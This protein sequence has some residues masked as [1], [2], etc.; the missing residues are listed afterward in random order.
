MKKIFALLAGLSL[1][2]SC[3]LPVSAEDISA[4]DGCVYVV[5]GIDHSGEENKYYLHSYNNGKGSTIICEKELNAYDQRTALE[6]G[7]VVKIWGVSNLAGQYY[8]SKLYPQAEMGNDGILVLGSAESYFEDT[9]EL[10]IIEVPDEM[11]F[12]EEKEDLLYYNLVLK[13]S[14]AN[15]YQY[16]Y[17]GFIEMEFIYNQ[18][19]EYQ[20]ETPFDAEKFAVGQTWNFVMNGEDVV[21]PLEMVSADSITVKPVSAVTANGDAD[22]NGALDILDIITVNKAVLG[23]EN[24]DA[25]RIPYIDFNQNQVPDSD[26]A[27]TMLKML[28]G[29][30]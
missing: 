10:T 17:T 26:D 22:G 25:E 2:S 9:K 29:L 4:S 14:E 18:G 30:A 27:L 16:Q 11:K 21:L 20:F 13:D 12:D 6:Y 24:L 8:F 3:V 23:K 7:D 19:Q 28:V 5:M 15:F 1:L